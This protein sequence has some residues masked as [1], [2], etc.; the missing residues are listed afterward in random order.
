MDDNMMK[1]VCESTDRIVANV[2][3][4]Q[5][6]LPT[7]CSEWN[8]GQLSNHLLS[9]LILGTALLSDTRPAVAAGPGEVPAED[10]IGNDLIGAYRS[11]VS[12]LVAATTVDAVSRT[13]TTPLGEMPGMGIAGFT[14]LDILVHGWDLAKAT[15]QPTDLDPQ[16]AEQLLGF[17]QQAVGDGEGRG[18]LIGPAIAVD[19]HSDATKIGRASCREMEYDRR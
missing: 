17:A 19:T 4:A 6:G 16:L 11:G 2:T 3:P 1:S 7:P 9:T 18:P 8:V 10:L 13:H 5:F 15:G 12:G 14:A